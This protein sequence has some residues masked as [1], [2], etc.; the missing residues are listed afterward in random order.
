[1]YRTRLPIA[2]LALLLSAPSQAA[3]IQV[4]LTGLTENTTAFSGDP[5]GS[6]LGIGACDGEAMQI[7]IQIDTDSAPAD[8]N[9]AAD[10]GQYSK[11]IP[12]GF[13]AATATINGRV[14]TLPV[15]ASVNHTVDLY[16]DLNTGPFGV[17]DRVQ[18][19]MVGANAGATETF[20]ATPNV[21]MTPGAFTG[22]ALELLAT[23]AGSPLL[24]SDTTSLSFGSFDFSNANGRVAGLFRLSQV[25]FSPVP[26]PPAVWLLGTAVAGLVVRRWQRRVIRA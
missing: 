6:G 14:F 12:P 22:D 26:A 9:I 17:R 5:C 4:T 15:E 2:Y 24:F 25:E 16:D 20:T 10:L 13:L 23:I 18:F 19:G 1:M 7:S 3:V 21:V 8:S 11:P